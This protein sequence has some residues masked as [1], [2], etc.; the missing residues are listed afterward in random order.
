MSLQEQKKGASLLSHPSVPDSAWQVGHEAQEE[1]M[2]KTAAEGA[3]FFVKPSSF[4]IKHTTEYLFL[5]FFS[6]GNVK[7]GT[8][9]LE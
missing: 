6:L 1:D 9:A 5:F 7:D 3:L 2:Q 4:I 8:Q